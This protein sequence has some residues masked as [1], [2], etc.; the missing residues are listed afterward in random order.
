MRRPVALLCLVFALVLTG[1]CV[2]IEGRAQSPPVR[3]K[4]PRVVISSGGPYVS[5]NGSTMQQFS[6]SINV[7]GRYAAQ[8]LSL[9]FTNGT[10]RAV[11]YQWL[12]VFLLPGGADATIQPSGQPTG[13]L[14][15]DANS[16][17]ATPQVYVDMT[18]QLLPGA[19][20][21]AIEGA[22]IRGAS[23]QWE[24]RSIGTPEI[25]A[26]RPEVYA[27]G[28]FMLYGSGFSLR[29][30]ENVVQMG[31]SYLP[32]LQSNFSEL[33]LKVPPGWPP[34]TYDLTVALQEY[35]SQKIS[36]VVVKP[37]SRN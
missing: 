28:T 27:G 32:V 4:L 10:E 12:R 15:I 33:Q 34:G 31:D 17:L 18:G 8:P 22:G 21:V 35:R 29:P 13:R 25:S 3:L 36:V 30:E 11:E 9:V 26:G 23:F 19:N 14:L 20:K 2:C 6:D 16:F 1:L 7:P 5:S 37:P 24:L